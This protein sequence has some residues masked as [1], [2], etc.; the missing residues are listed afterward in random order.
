MNDYSILGL[1]DGIKALSNN[2]TFKYKLD[3]NRFNHWGGIFEAP[4][5]YT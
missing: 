4:I 2:A 5:S 3:A 1:A